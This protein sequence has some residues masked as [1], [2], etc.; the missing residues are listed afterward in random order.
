MSEDQVDKNMIADLITIGD[1][2]VLF[3]ATISYKCQELCLQCFEKFNI[4]FARTYRFTFFK[5]ISESVILKKVGGGKRR[6]ILETV[7]D[8]F[9][10]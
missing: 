10:I 9:Q 5:K 6:N 8:L 1:H 3:I 7:K 2:C 4:L